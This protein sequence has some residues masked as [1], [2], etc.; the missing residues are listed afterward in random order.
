MQKVANT[1]KLAVCQVKVLPEKMD[2]LASVKKS[3]EEA[4]QNGAKITVLGETFNSIYTPKYLHAAAE[5]F[6][7]KNNCPT[8]QLLEELSL[9]H[10]IYICGSIPEKDNDK[11]YNTIV[12]YNN[13][14]ELIK[15]YRKIHLFDIDIPG[16]ATYKESNT[17][18]PGNQLT[19]VETEL[20]TFGL[21]ICYDI[22]FP[23]YAL[24]LCQK[25][26]NVL[27]YPGNFSP[28]TGPLHWRLLLQGRALDNLSYVV[29]ASTRRYVE[30]P[31][32]YQAYGHSQIVDP[33]GKVVVE[34]DEKE[35]IIYHDIDLD[36]VKQVRQQIPIYQQ[37]RNDIYELKVVE[38]SQEKK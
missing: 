17:F 18:G 7:D 28:A 25:G 11:L 26:A 21:G 4:A 8:L 16:K 14:G 13:K 33:F 22:R 32:V 24:A 3:I 30:D 23:E 38:N 15:T 34:T 9:K 37:K 35:A 5:N 2:T 19:V 6:Q 27:I 1:F 31:S 10:K 20:A 12:F 36:Y 29:G